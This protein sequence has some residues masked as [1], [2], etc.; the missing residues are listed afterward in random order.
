M[1]VARAA[2]EIAFVP[3]DNGIAF[4]SV[5]LEGFPHRDPA[6][7]LIVATALQLGATL[8]TADQRLHGYAAVST[9][10]D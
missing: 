10:R 2:P 9:L 3:V 1:L 5:D 8:V 4:Q 6:A 7:R